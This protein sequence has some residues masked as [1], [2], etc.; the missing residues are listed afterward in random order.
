MI[1]L[2]YITFIGFVYQASITIVLMRAA[3]QYVSY[4]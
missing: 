3:I 1:K 4:D 2:N